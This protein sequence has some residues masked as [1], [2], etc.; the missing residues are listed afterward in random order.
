M[1]GQIELEGKETGR[2]L[3]GGQGGTRTILLGRVK[4]YPK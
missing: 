3:E 4:K 1:R 2:N